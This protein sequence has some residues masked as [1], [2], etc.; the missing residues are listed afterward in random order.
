[1]QLAVVV[2]GFS[3]LNLVGCGP[4]APVVTASESVGTP[5]RAKG[6]EQ[7]A[8]ERRLRQLEQQAL[9]ELRK[10]RRSRQASSAAVQSPGEEEPDPDAE[11]LVFGGASHEVFLGCLC[12]AQHADSVFNMLGHHGSHASP[13]S[14]RNKF[15]V[16]GSNY[17]DT[18]A[19]SATATHPP[20]VVAADGKSLGLLTTNS[21]LK[22][23]ISA[24]SVADWL[25]RMC[26]E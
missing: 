8:L 13:A 15:A 14:I 24:P 26:G 25:A 2:I 21:E 22:R 6:G 12:D 5:E 3:A 1:M 17:D 10:L 9:A 19:C 11:L 16:Y 20:V 23:R 7:K 18:S 4:P